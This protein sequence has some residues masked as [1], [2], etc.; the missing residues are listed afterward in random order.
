[1]Q[2]ILEVFKGIKQ[3]ANIQSRMKMVLISHMINEEIEASRKGIAHTFAKFYGDL[4]SSGKPEHS[5]ET[6]GE[7]AVLKYDG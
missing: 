7:D 2:R 3:S 1:M 6:C 4:Y 5:K